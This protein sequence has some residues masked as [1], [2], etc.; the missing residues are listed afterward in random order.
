MS[1]VI[2]TTMRPDIQQ[3]FKD[4][5]VPIIDRAIIDAAIN[6]CEGILLWRE[7][8]TAIDIVDS[9][10]TYTLSSISGD[11]ATV[12]QAEFDESALRGTTEVFL[13][14]YL[15]GIPDWR[16]EESS[17]PTWFYLDPLRTTMRLVYTPDD[18]LTGGLVVQVALKPSRTATTLPDFLYKH[19]LEV[20]RMG[21][22]A[23]ILGMTEQPWAKPTVAEYYAG[24]FT[25]LLSREK[26]K[27]LTNYGALPVVA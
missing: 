3:D 18:D 1:V 24:K 14:E 5:P 17:S 7:E 16:S 12:M 19:F 9:Q 25:S 13:D 22:K 10:A 21:A 26:V 11:I 27:W 15:G 20:I 4:V 2:A 23:Y 8:L 6:I